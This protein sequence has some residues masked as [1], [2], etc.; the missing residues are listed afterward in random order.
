MDCITE[1][2][3]EVHAIGDH[4]I[5]SLHELLRQVPD[6]RAKRG[7]RYEA[8]TV[9]VILLLAKLAG[10]STLSGIAHWARLRESWL[11]QVLGLT[12]LP[13]ANTYH[14]VC[15]HLALVDLTTKVREWLSQIAPQ[16]QADELVQWALDGK[17]LRGTRRATPTAQSAQEV[18]NVYDVATGILQYCQTIASKGYEAASAYAF[19]GQTNCEGIVITADALHTRPRFCRRIRQQ[20]GHY[21]LMV[22]GNRA[23]LEAE[24]RHL[25]AL[26]PTPQHPVQ[27][28]QTVEAGHGRLIT[29]QIWTSRELNLALRQ[30]WCDV[31]QVFVVERRG[32]RNGKPFYESV[33]GLTSLPP[34]LASPA[35]L[36]ALV[37]QHWCIE[38]R[39][40]WR[41]DATLH[42]DACTVRHPQVATILAVLNT[43]ILALLDH[44]QVTN[45]RRAL[46]TFAA[47]PPQALALLT[48][49]L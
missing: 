38:N 44:C 1:R 43:A 12:R 27:T 3:D 16:R 11:R 24:I 18:L 4:H 20:Q 7:R 8:A 26:P 29:R 5:Q 10:E 17:V 19:V 48:Q 41:R 30:E 2:A 33:C 35:Q 32:M 39:C 46:R 25:F 13:C 14:Y 31:A 37:Q 45:T 15:A 9:L 21:V 47:F 22:K 6:H 34:E 42:E 23:Q 40:H 49:P 28:A 36:L